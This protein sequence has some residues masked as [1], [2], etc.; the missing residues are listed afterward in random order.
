[1][2]YDVAKTMIQL[3][4]RFWILICILGLPALADSKAPTGPLSPVIRPPSGKLFRF[5]L[6]QEPLTLDWNQG[7]IHPL[8]IQNI[9]RG[10]Y[11]VGD[12]GEI[13]PDLVQSAQV[14][15]KGKKWIFKLKPKV[16]WS[17][18]APLTADHAVASLKRLLDPS[19]R[20]RFAFLLFD[21]EGAR[22]YNQGNIHG[23]DE[24][25][26][27]LGIR[28]I[29]ELTF[30]ITLKRPA[31]FLPAIL[32]HSATFPIRPDLAERW[33]DHWIN[34]RHLATLGSFKVTDWLRQTR[35]ILSPHPHSGH[36][37]QS[38][39]PWFEKVEAWVILDDK[40][41]R[42]LYQWGHLE[43]MTDPDLGLKAHPDLAYMETPAPTFVG[44]GPGHPLTSARA[45]VLALSAALDRTQLPKVLNVP[46]RPALD[47]CPPEVWKHLSAAST[48]AN[49]DVTSGWFL[50]TI[51]PQGAPELAKSLMKEALLEIEEKVRKNLPPLVLWHTRHSEYFEL[52]RWIQEQWRS[53]LGLRVTLASVNP[54]RFELTLGRNPKPLFLQ[55]ESAAFPDPDA[56]FSLFATHN[57]R[58][59]GRW[60]DSDYENWL[61]KAK[62]GPHRRDHY[63][64]I[65]RRLLVEKPAII[66]LYFATVS[67]LVKPYVKDLAFSPA[68]RV[69]FSSASYLPNEARSTPESGR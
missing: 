31:P 42:N 55:V 63:T 25:K 29:S 64:K 62:H 67:Y 47:Y 12:N 38:P 57:P 49:E 33:A 16:L 15:E 58:N 40:T 18:G 69:D 48:P 52:A 41:A 68:A 3:A 20:S 26:A 36:A 14:M 1:M 19:T 66:P 51:P 54:E 7:T 22:V 9:M 32:T 37:D 8:L 30:E 6:P 27:P 45:G 35:L 59:L 46:H 21:I 2:R 5:R 61:Q 50:D 65:S 53:K 44:I 39:R 43:F 24:E 60:R 23:T 34:P 13:V 10:L 11:R 17:D 28:V 4:S 56:F